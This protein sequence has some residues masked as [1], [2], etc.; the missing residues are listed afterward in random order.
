MTRIDHTGHGHDATP[1]GRDLCRK[2]K[3]SVRPFVTNHTHYSGYLIQAFNAAGQLIDMDATPEG[4]SFHVDTTSAV[5]WVLNN[6]R[7]GVLHDWDAET[8]TVH[9]IRTIKVVHTTG[10][11]PEVH[12]IAAD[13]TRTMEV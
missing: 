9:A 10:G 8:H 6:L 7:Y 11:K 12:R 13:G 3:L 4:E 2:L 5:V 1:A